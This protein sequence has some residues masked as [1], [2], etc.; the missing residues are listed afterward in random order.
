ML[1]KKDKIELFKKLNAD[2][3]T[4]ENAE[5]TFT[6]GHKKYTPT[7]E[8]SPARLI[9]DFT[10]VGNNEVFCYFPSDYPREAALKLNGSDIGTFFGNETFRILSL[11]LR[12]DS[13]AMHLEMT[14]NDDNLYIAS[15][16]DYFYY[17]DAELFCEIMPQ[18]RQAELKINSF[19]D[20]K[21]EGSI[22]IPAGMTTLF[23]SIPYDEGWQVTVD[24]VKTGISKTLGSLLAVNLSEGTHEIVMRYMPRCFTV[25]LTVSVT[26]LAAFAAVCA[27]DSFIKK[28]NR[29]H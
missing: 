19:R 14:L 26:G 1:G 10:A 12:Q 28:K 13:D 29:R 27:V 3:I 25:G 7:I 4:Y 22:T 2:D 17:L 21:I 18:L 24:G 11:G 5:V 16:V 6:T 9:F 20:T 8:G 23:T 15:G